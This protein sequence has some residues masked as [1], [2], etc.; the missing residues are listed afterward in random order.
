MPLDRHT[1]DIGFRYPDAVWT[2]SAA[3]RRRR[4]RGNGDVHS[5]DD[6]RFFIRGVAYVPMHGEE[7]NRFGWGLWAEVAPEV[8]RR[9][10][11]MMH[12]DGSRETPAEGLVANTPEGYED[13][14]AQRV[15]IHF[16]P[17]V[18]RPTFTLLPSAHRLY[19]EQRDG[20]GA[21]RLHEIVAA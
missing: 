8:F 17:S 6:E 19:R 7:R 13:T 10:V 3:D 15:R 4:A 9:Y 5:L 16:G 12:R 1:V 20:I 11:S 21:A 14:S 18:E 2:L